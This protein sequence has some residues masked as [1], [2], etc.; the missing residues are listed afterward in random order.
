MNESSVIEKGMSFETLVSDRVWLIPENKPGAETPVK[1][2]VRITNK[3]RQSMR[4]CIFRMFSPTLIGP[5]GKSLRQEGGSN[6]SRVIRESDCPF[7]S[8]G[9]GLTFFLEGKLT[10]QSHQICLEGLW[11]P[12]GT[13]QFKDIKPGSYSFSFRY[14]CYPEKGRLSLAIRDIW[15]EIWAGQIET[16]VID[17]SLVL[18]DFPSRTG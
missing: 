17:I 2:G 18:Q 8:P 12:G 1:L 16:P 9:E 6:P 4:F 3:A 7:V 13:W 10:W 5:E 15:E 14:T 11:E